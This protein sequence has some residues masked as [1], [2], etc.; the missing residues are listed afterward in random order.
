MAMKNLL[1]VLSVLFLSMLVSCDSNDEPKISNSSTLDVTVKNNEAYTHDLGMLGIEDQASFKE[2]PDHA[3]TS[4]LVRNGASHIIY[5]YQAEDNYTGPDEA[6]IEICISDG[7]KCVSS[8]IVTI[9][10]NVTN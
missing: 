5:T 4:S 10:I 8:R 2:T 3:K 6:A 7:A 1:F 9:K